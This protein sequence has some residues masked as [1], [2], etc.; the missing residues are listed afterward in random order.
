MAIVRLSSGYRVAIEWLSCG[1]PRGPVMPSLLYHISA[2]R[3]SSED[4]FVQTWD[5]E[6]DMG[7]ELDWWWRRAK[8]RTAFRLCLDDLNQD[9]YG[10][11][12]NEYCLST[13]GYCSNALATLSLITTLFPKPSNLPEISFPQRRRELTSPRLKNKLSRRSVHIRKWKKQ[14]HVDG[15]WTKSCTTFTMS[16]TLFENASLS[17][18][19]NPLF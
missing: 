18:P 6:F 1:Y 9:G 19:C 15:W 2:K 17:I 16:K 13:T 12:L 7:Q 3:I 8:D 5:F 14:L 10:M 11:L 4:I